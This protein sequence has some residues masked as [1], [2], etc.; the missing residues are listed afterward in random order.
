MRIF[1]TGFFRFPGLYILGYKSYICFGKRANQQPI[2]V[3]MVKKLI[4]KY[5]NTISG[6]QLFQLLRTGAFFLTSIVFVKSNQ[7]TGSIGA[8]EIFLFLSSLLC[9]FWI[10]GLIQSF[11]PLSAENKTFAKKNGNKS[12]ELFNAFIL[13]TFLSLMVILVLLIFRG[14]L[15]NILNKSEEIPFYWQLLL[16]IFFSCPSY[17]VEYIY[18]LKDKP[19]WILRYGILTF[20]LQ[21]LMVSL[22]AVL[23][24][25]MEYCID[26]LVGISVL[27][28][29]WLLVMLKKYSEPTFSS[30]FIKEHLVCGLPL[31]ISA[32]LA[33]AS[34]YIDG[35][36]VLDR[37]DPSTFAVFRYGAREFPLIVLL[38]NAFSIAMIPK[39]SSSDNFKEALYNLRK[40][41]ENMMHFLFPA[42][43]VM[44]LTA[45]WLYPVIFNKNFAE[46]AH[47]FNIY[48]LMISSRLVF[49]HTILIGLKKTRIV[50][51]ASI[52]E[53]FINGC[54]S[55]LF[56]GFWGIEGVAFAAL[57]AY[58][59]QKVIWISYNRFVLKIHTRHYIPLPV[60]AAYSLVLV[61]IFYFVY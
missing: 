6:L 23:G 56:V 36:I 50:M 48:L 21:V 31:I 5:L 32:L 26:G 53:F 22:P 44:L 18:L 30:I 46:S 61:V 27:R 55:L 1:Q 60:L 47:V 41:S 45:N 34:V 37:F 8:Y 7:S 57:I 14:P 19:G 33:S 13:I 29:L 40:K 2:A 17:L 51:Y 38:A 9:S 10:N 25:G 35:V 49:P 16:F 24:F 15:S 11:L 54:L 12:P 20:S 43:A 58:S 39:F 52:A 42:T 28:Y 3:F 59:A 4:R